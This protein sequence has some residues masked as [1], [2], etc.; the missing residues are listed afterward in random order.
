MR[1]VYQTDMNILRLNITPFVFSVDRKK[2]T[3]QA[4]FLKTKSGSF[5]ENKTEELI[6]YVFL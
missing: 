5:Y 2:A 1:S 3:F 4:Y 6:V